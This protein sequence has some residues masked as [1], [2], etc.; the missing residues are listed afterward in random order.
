MKYYYI[1][2]IKEILFEPYNYE[3]QIY[4]LTL[5]VKVKLIREDMKHFTKEITK[6]MDLKI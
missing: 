5:T 2:N 4:L 1:D 6:I 3:E